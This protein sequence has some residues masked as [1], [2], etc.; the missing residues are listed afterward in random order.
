MRTLIVISMLVFLSACGKGGGAAS[1]GSTSPGGG[2]TS[3]NNYSI[4][5]TGD[6]THAPTF[7]TNSFDVD[8]TYPDYYQL[9]LANSG[10]V[11]VPANTQYEYD[12]TA[13][14]LQ[15]MVFQVNALNGSPSMT[16]KIIKNGVQVEIT[17]LNA[18]GDFHDFSNW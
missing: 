18:N 3:K 15:N 14:N 17:T 9:N 7:V 12:L 10:P 1:T 6:A 11:T 5:I 2:S 4:I 8:K 16:A 13:Y